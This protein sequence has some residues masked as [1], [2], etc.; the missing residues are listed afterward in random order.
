M[1]QIIYKQLISIGIGSNLKQ[2]T[3][4]SYF[5][6][7]GKTPKKDVTLP[8]AAAVTASPPPP[9]LLFYGSK[10]VQW[11]QIFSWDQAPCTVKIH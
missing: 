9:P 1:T 10:K 5:I 7:P 2:N 3:T 6:V 8:Y 11:E 4:L